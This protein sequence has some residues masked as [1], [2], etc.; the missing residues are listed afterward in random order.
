M[1]KGEW[2]TAENY[3]YCLGS[4]VLLSW[5]AWNIGRRAEKR[6]IFYL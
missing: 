1:L 2:P 5:L 4:I 3:Y 6:V